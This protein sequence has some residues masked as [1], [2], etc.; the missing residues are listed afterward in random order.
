[1]TAIAP[2]TTATPA[3][4]HYLQPGW[5][6]R[7]LMNRPIRRL[8]RLGIR[9]KGLRELRVR[10]RAS[11]EW[12]TT[13]VNL[14]ELPTGRYLVSPRGVSQW[15]RNMRV[16]GGGELRAGR[17]TEAFQA[18]ELTDVDAAVPVLRAYLQQWAWE[19]GAFFDGTGADA[20]DD[21]LAAI[22]HRHPIFR[23]S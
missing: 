9:P 12:R 21:E 17:R 6:T 19:V 8:S 20:S 10:G 3:T 13:P 15:V 7:N 1:M 14:L 5:F 2:P 11:G 4:D 23:L 22:V 16:A 18:T